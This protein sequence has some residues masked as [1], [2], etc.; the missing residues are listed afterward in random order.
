MRTLLINTT[1]ESA[2]L[3]HLTTIFPHFI[4]YY[5]KTPM[6]YASSEELRVLNYSSMINQLVVHSTTYK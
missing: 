2:H 3:V 4:Y 5:R 6:I 1:I